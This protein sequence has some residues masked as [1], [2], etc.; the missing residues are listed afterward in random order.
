MVYAVHNLEETV[1]EF[2]KK[3]GV[4]PIFGGY[5][6]S[7]GTKNALINLNNESYLELLSVDHTNTIISSPRWMGVDVLSKNQITRIALKSNTLENDQA[8]LKKH[9]ATMGKISGGSR[10]T[11]NG[12]VLQWRLIMPLSTPEV[13][14]APFMI[15]WSKSQAHPSTSL[16]DMGC[17]LIELYA[18]H[19]RPEQIRHLYETLDFKIEIK[20]SQKISLNMVLNTPNGN[21]TL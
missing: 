7:Q 11:T 13:E 19:P 5:H 18:T 20:E 9:D 10:N 16:P 4:R 8:V 15:D 12:S 17:T 6:R 1:L 2:E 3:L 14:L 21:I